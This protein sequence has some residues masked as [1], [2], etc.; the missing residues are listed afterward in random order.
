MKEC[1]KAY[2]QLREEGS[3]T[4]FVRMGIHL[5]ILHRTDRHEQPRELLF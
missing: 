2:L 5:A 3:L 4:G 1:R